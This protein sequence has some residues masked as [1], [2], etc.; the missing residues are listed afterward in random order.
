MIKTNCCLGSL[1]SG[2]GKNLLPITM[3]TT[4]MPITT[5]MITM[6]MLITMPVLTTMPL[7]T[8]TM[9]LTLITTLI[10]T[11]MTSA[12][13]PTLLH[14]H[15]HYYTNYYTNYYANTGESSVKYPLCISS[16]FNMSTKLFKKYIFCIDQS[17]K[18]FMFRSFNPCE[19][20]EI[21]QNMQT[22]LYHTIMSSWWI[23]IK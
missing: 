10:M 23:A 1:L 7:T 17:V 12:L 16:I 5:P 3:P 14:W 8:V 11:P 19:S 22:K 4:T 9:T 20:G 13:T 6:P 18:P 21:V 15:R 2:G